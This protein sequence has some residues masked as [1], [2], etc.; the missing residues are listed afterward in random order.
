MILRLFRTGDLIK[1]FRKGGYKKLKNLWEE[2]KGGAEFMEEWD[3]K[4]IAV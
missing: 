2:V 3:C 1:C 4:T